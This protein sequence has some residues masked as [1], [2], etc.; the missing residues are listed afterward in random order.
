MEDA[1][2]IIALGGGGVTKVVMGDRIERIFNFKDPYE[3][4][5]RFDEILE[6]KQEIINL[7]K[8]NK[9]NG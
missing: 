2:T 9:E 4:I 1:Q 7:Y 5:N 8:G 6:K 3:Y